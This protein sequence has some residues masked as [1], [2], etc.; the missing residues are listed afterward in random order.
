MDYTDLLKA[1]TSGNS[2]QLGFSLLHLAET[3]AAASGVHPKAIVTQAL[4]AGKEK[5]EQATTQDIDGFVAYIEST[6]L[7]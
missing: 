2:A 3:V 1:V 7:K 4:E 5:L 6:Y